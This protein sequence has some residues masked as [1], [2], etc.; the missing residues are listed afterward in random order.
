M[1]HIHQYHYRNITSGWLPPSVIQPYPLVAEASTSRENDALGAEASD[2]HTSCRF[3]CGPC[4]PALTRDGALQGQVAARIQRLGR[5]FGD[6][7]LVARGP[8]E[9]AGH[10]ALNHLRTRNRKTNT[11]MRQGVC[12]LRGVSRWA[13]WMMQQASSHVSM[14]EHVR[15]ECASAYHSLIVCHLSIFTLH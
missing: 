4:K 1:V 3:K 14:Q 7:V 15:K 6:S 8:P 13:S 2:A 9:V 11:N 12:A 10:L 5:R